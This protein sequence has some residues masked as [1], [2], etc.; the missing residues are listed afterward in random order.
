M[1]HKTQGNNGESMVAEGHNGQKFSTFDRDNDH[2]VNNSAASFKGAWWFNACRHSNLNGR[3]FHYG[4]Y[5]SGS[6]GIHWY[7]HDKHKTSML[8]AE[9]K[10]RI[11][12]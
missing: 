2:W 7:A 8:G 1:D 11:K 9:M 10:M 3:Y 12:D 4:D 5:S 6:N